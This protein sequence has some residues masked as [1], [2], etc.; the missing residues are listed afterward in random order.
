MYDPRPR[1]LQHLDLSR[2]RVEFAPTIFLCGGQVDHEKPNQHS[3]RKSLLENIGKFP[4]IFQDSILLA[5]EF[6][7][8]NADGVFPDLMTF[9]NYLA[10]IAHR[11]VLILESA[12]TIAELGAFSQ[13]KNLMKKMLVIGQA[14]HFNQSSFIEQAI[15]KFLSENE[16]QVFHYDWQPSTTREPG[17]IPDDVINH[18]IGDIVTSANKT[19]SA[20]FEPDNISHATVFVKEII[21]LFIALTK[22]EIE[23]CLELAG[24]SLS[25]QEIKRIIYILEAFEVIK[26]QANGNIYF[27]SHRTAFHQL[28]LKSTPGIE[29]NQVTIHKGGGIHSDS[30][31]LACAQYYKE[32][33]DSRRLGAIK[34]ALDKD[35]LK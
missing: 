17:Y 13:N 23:T 33:R 32:S 15:L 22:I 28:R 14:E 26:K 21:R 29:I 25:P 3:L 9:E 2:S 18:V 19:Q 35:L 10:G 5:E 31:P 8:Y 4:P 27:V 1:L 11:V 24:F 30:I 7:D 20:V 34:E 16:D 6:K 12:G